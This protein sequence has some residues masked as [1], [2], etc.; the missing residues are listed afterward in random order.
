MWLW[1]VYAM[2]HKLYVPNYFCWLPRANVPINNSICLSKIGHDKQD[3]RV[4]TSTGNGYTISVIFVSDQV[5]SSN[6]PS[7]WRRLKEEIAG[8]KERRCQ[9]NGEKFLSIQ[10]LRLDFPSCSP[11]SLLLLY[12]FLLA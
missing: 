6:S 3:G 11:F 2:R 8:Q 1:G 5:R 10:K 7:G 12:L 9:E 4:R